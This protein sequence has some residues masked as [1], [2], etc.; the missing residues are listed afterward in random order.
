VYFDVVGPE[1]CIHP[2]ACEDKNPVKEGE[3]QGKESCHKNSGYE[4]G[5]AE[6]RVALQEHGF[7]AKETEYT[8]KNNKQAKREGMANEQDLEQAACC[9]SF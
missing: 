5:Y 3:Q 1:P 4:T 7:I 8:H 2:V 9:D 6:Y